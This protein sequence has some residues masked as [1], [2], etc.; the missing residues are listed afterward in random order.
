MEHR[1]ITYQQVCGEYNADKAELRNAKLLYILMSVLF[2]T[3]WVVPQYFG[4][5]IAFDF[6]AT[7]VLNVLVLAYFLMNRKVGNHFFRSMLDV[8]VTPY[9][10]VYMFVMVYTTVLRVNIN[11][12]F[13]NFL[14]I[15]TFYMVYYGVR[16]VIGVRKSIDWSVKVAWFLGLYGLVEYVLGFSPMVKFLR[17]LP[18][19]N[20]ISVYRSGSYRIMGPCVHSIGYGLM[21]ELLLVIICID[22]NRNE[23]N[24]FKHPVLY[25]VLILNM[26]LTGS[27]LALGFAIFESALIVLFSKR[28][29]R[30]ETLFVLVVFLIG[31]ALFEVAIFKT[32]LGQYIMMQITSLI[33]E[34]LGTEFAASFGADTTWLADSTTYRGYLPKIFGVDWL[35]PFVGQGVNASFVFAIEDMYLES[36]DNFYVALY[37]R[38]AYPGMIAYI[39]FFLVTIIKMVKKY[40]Q[41]RSMLC[42]ALAIGMTTYCVSLYWVDYLQTTKYMYILVAIFEAF[43]NEKREEVKE[44][45]HNN[46]LGGLDGTYTKRTNSLS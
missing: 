14:D 33:D 12:F 30:K 32:S 34:A 8:Q 9:L 44:G 45:S 20:V 31:F 42:I 21:L 17:T 3:D 36:I 23:L 37:I 2:V 11:T 28:K 10:L 46:I 38:Y 13:L 40:M 25:C 5:H 19:D 6:T 18:Y 24:L 29:K 1:G 43:C 4:V 26:F 15:L 41:D 16:Y 35:S 27:R 39:L 7:R 22:Y